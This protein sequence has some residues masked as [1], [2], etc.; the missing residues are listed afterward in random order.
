MR[1]TGEIGTQM[2]QLSSALDAFGIRH[3]SKGLPDLLEVAERNDLTNREFLARLLECEVDGR[4]ARM[5][6][7][8]LFLWYSG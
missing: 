5:R 4:N 3:A 6:C 2:G 1:I 8:V 7:I